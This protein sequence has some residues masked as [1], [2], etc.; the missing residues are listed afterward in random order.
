M[1]AEFGVLVGDGAAD[2]AAVVAVED[3]TVGAKDRRAGV[4]PVRQGHGLAVLVAEL[5]GCM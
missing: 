2:V 3:A 1:G 4:A 5:C